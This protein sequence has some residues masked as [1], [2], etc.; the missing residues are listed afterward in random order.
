MRTRVFFPNLDALRFLAFL[1]VFLFHSF[2]TEDPTLRAHPIL[3]TLY[4][5]KRSGSL[6]VNFFFVLSGFLITFLLL[7]E[8]AQRETID[9]PAFYLRRLLR[10]W[11]LYFL[12]L[13]LGFALFPLLKLRLGL[14]PTE[15]ATLWKYVLFLGNF[16][17]IS[18]GRLP[19]ASLLGVLWSLAVEEQFYLVWPLLLAVL[20]PRHYPKL[21]L[22]I[23]AAGCV[24][25]AIYL[26][27]STRLSFSTFA[28]SSDLAVGAALAFCSHREHPWLGRLRGLDVR[29]LGGIYLIGVTAVFW[30]HR[31]EMQGAWPVG[32]F[33]RPL[34]SL[35]FAFVIWEQNEAVNS[36]FKL[37][38][39]GVLSALGKISYGLYCWHFVGILGAIHLNRLVFQLNTQWWHIVFLEAAAAL[40]IT[41]AVSAGSYR[42]FESPFLRLKQRFA[43]VNRPPAERASA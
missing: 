2:H 9:I 10:I 25:R 20:A 17:I 7:E 23:I 6:G 11:P 43:I 4:E 29:V 22:S 35:F 32:I 21:F 31:Q 28:V 15:S 13:A 12:I 41:I 3:E 39:L 1:A 24:Y 5:L 40:A 8:R 34:I 42:Y 33:S 14:P 16:D 36:P 30:L 18:D 19:D 37:G 38:R 27:D 26:H